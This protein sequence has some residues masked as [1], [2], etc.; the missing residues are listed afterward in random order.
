MSKRGEFGEPWKFLP[1]EDIDMACEVQTSHEV[2]DTTGRFP[3]R[4]HYDDAAREWN[5]WAVSCAKR[6]V[7]CINA[8]DGCDPTKLAELLE[9]VVEI[10]VDHHPATRLAVAYRAFRGEA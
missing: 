5:Q 7:A 8:L 4:L 10:A 2:T 9:A 3:F 6:A 1:A